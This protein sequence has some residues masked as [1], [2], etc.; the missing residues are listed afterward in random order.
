MSARYG[1]QG[2]ILIW[3]PAQAASEHIWRH[4]ANARLAGTEKGQLT[5]NA[6]G[7]G[8]THTMT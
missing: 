3:W 6:T 7:V 8:A 5:M 2:R 4:A 1:R